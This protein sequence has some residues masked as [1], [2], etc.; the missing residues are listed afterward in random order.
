MLAGLLCSHCNLL[1][2]AVFACQITDRSEAFWAQIKGEDSH[3]P[4]ICTDMCPPLRKREFSPVSPW[5]EL[6]FFRRP[7]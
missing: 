4:F 6:A 2:G 5:L 1:H 3:F 7:A